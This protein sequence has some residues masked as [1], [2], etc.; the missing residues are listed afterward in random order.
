MQYDG[1]STDQFIPYYASAIHKHTHTR[2]LKPFEDSEPTVLK[3]DTAS[4]HSCFSLMMMLFLLFLITSPFS[5][6][7]LQVGAESRCTGVGQCVPDAEC[8]PRSGGT[9]KCNEGFY[10]QDGQCRS[11]REVLHASFRNGTVL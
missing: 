1:I 3:V 5:S 9:C 10:P 11:V 8:T 6:C 2:I 4:S 7:C